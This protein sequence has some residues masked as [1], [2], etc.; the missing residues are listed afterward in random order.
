MSAS[1]HDGTPAVK[2]DV[3]ERGANGQCSSGCP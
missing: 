3:D 2:V 1:P